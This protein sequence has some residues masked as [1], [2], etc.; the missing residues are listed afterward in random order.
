[1]GLG[2]SVKRGQIL[3]TMKHTR[4]LVLFGVALWV[5]IGGFLQWQGK[6]GA[7]PAATVAVSVYWLSVVLGRM[8]CFGLGAA[9][10]GVAPLAVTGVR[11]MVFLPA[12]AAAIT[13]PSLKTFPLTTALVACYFP[14][15]VLESVLL[16]WQANSRSTED[17]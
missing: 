7:I 4:F 2:N 5:L 3:T 17:M 6:E 9:N 16:G 15:L 12:L 11:M 13:I 8:V 1:M 14:M 10:R